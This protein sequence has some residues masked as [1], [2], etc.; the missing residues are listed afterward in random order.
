MTKETVENAWAWLKSKRFALSA[1]VLLFWVTA[2][3]VALC[4]G[5]K[6]VFEFCTPWCLGS[7]GVWQG[8][9]T[10]GKKLSQ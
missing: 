4:G 8:W 6:E 7:I 10:L 3:I 1:P 5:T 9:D 2:G